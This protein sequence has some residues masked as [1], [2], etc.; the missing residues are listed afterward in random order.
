[1]EFKYLKL[2]Y[3]PDT[4]WYEIY[5]PDGTEITF[6]NYKVRVSKIDDS[7]DRRTTAI[8]QSEVEIVNERPM[9]ISKCCMTEIAPNTGDVKEK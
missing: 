7:V 9:S 8:F 3:N 2:W 6:G 1:M 4:K 5:L